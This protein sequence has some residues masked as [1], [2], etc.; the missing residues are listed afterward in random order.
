MTNQERIEKLCVGVLGW[1]RGTRFENSFA[2]SSKQIEIQTWFNEFEIAVR[3][4][5]D[6]DANLIAQCLA[7]LTEEEFEELAIKIYGLTDDDVSRLEIWCRLSLSEQA[8]K[9][10]EVKKL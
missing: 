8:D 9:I 1:K 3:R 10:I 4:L 2:D 6:L 5:P 7:N